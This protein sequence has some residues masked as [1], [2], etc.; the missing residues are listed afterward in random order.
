MK[1]RVILLAFILLL[2]SAAAVC[3][4]FFMR[5]YVTAQEEI[6]EYINIQSEYTTTTQI[7]VP[8]HINNEDDENAYPDDE[9]VVP[10]L[11]LPYVN[12]DFDAMLHAN[13]ETVGWIA[14]PDTVISYPVVQTTNNSKYLGISFEGR[15]SKAGTLFADYRNNMEILDTNTIIY[16]HNMGAGRNDMFNTL[17][18]YKDYEYFMAHQYI[19]FDT[20]YEQHGFWKVFAVIEL[21][22]RNNT[23]YYQQIEFK[24]DIQFVNWISTAQSLSLHSISTEINPQDRTLALST[25]DRSRYGGYGRLIILAVRIH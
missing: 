5:E 15:S 2:I 6:S 24:D 19:Q 23:F 20:I 7:Q 8:V 17:L 14:I 9:V 4:Y 1:K 25:C 21:D 13:P 18:L 22:T 12:V 10:E 3:G 11:I 16:G